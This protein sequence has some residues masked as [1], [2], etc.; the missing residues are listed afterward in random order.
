MPTF[1]GST[2]Q[3]AIETGL[4]Q[5]G[6]PRDAVSVE[7]VQENKNGFLG[8]MRKPAIVNLKPL[9][10]PIDADPTPSDDPPAKPRAGKKLATALTD[11]AG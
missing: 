2:I 8:L 9:E 7:V 10:P 5:L 11:G 4:K 6:L 1:Q 3:K